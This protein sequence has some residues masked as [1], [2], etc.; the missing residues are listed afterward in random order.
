MIYYFFVFLFCVGNEGFDRNCGCGSKSL[1]NFVL[2]CI[3]SLLGFIF[4]FFNLI[5]LFKV[6]S[7]KCLECRGKW[8]LYRDSFKHSNSIVSIIITYNDF[9]FINDNI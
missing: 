3:K 9:I 2:K 5:L 7:Q 1:V 8:S 6:Q 4:L